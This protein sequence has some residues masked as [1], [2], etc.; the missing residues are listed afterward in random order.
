MT[1]TYDEHATAAPARVTGL[2]LAAGGAIGLL[3]AFVLTVERFR[4]LENPEHRLSCD[5]SPILSCGS[6]M[7]TEQARVFGFPNPLLGIG[8]FSVVLTLGVLLAGGVR[9][10]RWVLAGFAG[11]ACLGLA[12][13]AWLSFQS[14]YRIGALC[15][16]C[17]VVWSVTIPIA[18]WTVALAA[19]PHPFGRVL[20]DY[21]YLAVV[22]LY[23]ALVVQ[24]LVRFW[25]YWRTLV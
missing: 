14:M 9:L 6:V 25:D 13:V 21:R 19:R 18:V 3:A 8:A 5:L 2:A 16:W 23:L 15:P 11:G 22:T 24:A 20:W 4:L 7:V 17:M 10:P 1:E 12:F